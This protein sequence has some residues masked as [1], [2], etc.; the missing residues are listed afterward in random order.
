MTE[1]SELT[2]SDWSIPCC[3]EGDYPTPEELDNAFQLLEKGVILE[4]HW[5]SPGTRPRTP[6]IEETDNK[7]VQKET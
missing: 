6:V 5:K 1:I 7:E 4:L 2:S 3:E